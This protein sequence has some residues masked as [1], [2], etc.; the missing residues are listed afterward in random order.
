[1][2]G[3]PVAKSMDARNVNDKMSSGIVSG[4]RFINDFVTL[5]LKLGS[6]GIY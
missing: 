4:K 6:M 3:C 5:I 1:M 2:A